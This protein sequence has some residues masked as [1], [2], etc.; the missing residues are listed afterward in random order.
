MIQSVSIEHIFSIT[1]VWN[2][3]PCQHS[4][5]DEFD[6]VSRKS[7]TQPLQLLLGYE[8]GDSQA[9]QVLL[10]LLQTA[11]KFLFFSLEKKLKLAYHS[12]CDAKGG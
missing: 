10:V 3:V 1:V 9:Q 8:I 6:L 4:G 2:T 12:S 7:T 11:N 5:R